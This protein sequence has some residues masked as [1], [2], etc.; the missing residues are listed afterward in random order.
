MCTLLVSNVFPLKDRR[1]RVLS[2]HNSGSW[3]LYGDPQNQPFLK[4]NYYWMGGGGGTNTT[5]YKMTELRLASTN[6]VWPL[7]LK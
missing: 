1:N 6:P 4:E 5:H 7:M 3:A 2:K